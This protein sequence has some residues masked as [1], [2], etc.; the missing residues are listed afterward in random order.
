MKIR[1]VAAAAAVVVVAGTT[2]ALAMP[3]K[4][5]T[6]ACQAAGAGLVCSSLDTPGGGALDMDAWKRVA[7][8]DT[9]VKVYGE[10][11]TDPAEDFEMIQVGTDETPLYPGLTDKL[12]IVPGSTVMIEYAPE[13]VLSGYCISIITSTEYAH[14]ALR[15]CDV[16]SVSNQTYNQYQTF[17]RVAAGD[18]DGSSFYA[19]EN[20]LT[21]L[22]LTDPRN[23]PAGTA[24]VSA[25]VGT[26][27][28][29]GG[30]LWEANG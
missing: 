27:G 30:Q 11:V 29:S 8:S 3:S 6:P 19:L 2:A 7:A 10:S 17:V 12:E 25:P 26:E 16:P 24:V 9:P 20:V 1:L 15:P 5:A 4:A 13:G 21:G 28:F 22:T 23:G 18:A 14:A